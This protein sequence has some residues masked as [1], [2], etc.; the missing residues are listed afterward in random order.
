MSTNPMGLFRRPDLDRPR[1]ISSLPSFTPN[2]SVSSNFLSNTFCWLVKVLSE[3]T[4]VAVLLYCN[5]SLMRMKLNRYNLG[6][7]TIGLN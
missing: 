2:I 6:A 5:L 3:S 1:V 7:F 4:I